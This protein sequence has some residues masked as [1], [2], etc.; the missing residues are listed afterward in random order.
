MGLEARGFQSRPAEDSG[1]TLVL[2]LDTEEKLLASFRATTRSCIRRSI[3]AG[4]TVDRG[5]EADVLAGLAAQTASRQH[6]YV[7]GVSAF[8]ALL[9]CLDWCRTYVARYDGHAVAA[10]LIGQHDRRAYYLF[11]GSSGSY[12]E[13]MPAYAIQWAA[14]RDAFQA[15]CTEY[16]MWGIPPDG[17]PAHPMHGLWV[18]KTGFGGRVERR[19]GVWDL[20]LSPMREALGRRERALRIEMRKVRDRLRGHVT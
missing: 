16:D 8:Q 17:D 9:D 20:V 19:A 4:V 7:P 6:I 18:F 2:S 3:K 15:G 14:I 11:A 10:A 13:L 5:R 12:R 1:H